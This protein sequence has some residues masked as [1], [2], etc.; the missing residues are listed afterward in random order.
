[1]ETQQLM[2]RKEFWLAICAL[3]GFVYFIAL[4]LLMIV[5]TG[6]SI[7]RLAIVML[8]VHVAEI[9]LAVKRLADKNPDRNRLI[10]L[11]LIFGA[12]WWMPAQRGIFPVR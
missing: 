12:G 9:P 1:M 5:G 7:V 3:I 2:D 8:L 4:I 6:N 10:A 11:T